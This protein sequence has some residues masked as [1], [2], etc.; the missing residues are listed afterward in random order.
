MKKNNDYDDD[1]RM[2]AMCLAWIGFWCLFG[3]LVLI[4]MDLK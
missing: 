2:L 4:L 3:P 1:E